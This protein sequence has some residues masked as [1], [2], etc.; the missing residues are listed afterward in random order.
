M[1]YRH[2]LTILSIVFSFTQFAPAADTLESK[3]EA[4]LKAEPYANAHWGLLVVDSK[5]GKVVFEKNADQMF[6]PASVT[7]LFSTSAAFVDLGANHK[8]ETPVVRRGPVDNEGTL[9]GDLILVASGDLSLGGRTGPAGTLLFEDNDHIY[10]G[11]SNTGTLV[12]CD[13]LAGL[14]ELAK[15]ILASGIKRI[16][17][18]VL[19]DDRMFEPSV[20]TG[21]G[22]TH[23]SP[24][25]INDSIVD[26]L[27]T[28]GA[29][30]GDTAT[31]RTIPQ[32]AF[33]NVE[34]QVD[35]VPEGQRATA[36]VRSVGSRAF[37]VRGRVPVGHKP[38]LRIF[39]IDDPA[40]YARSLFIETLRRRGIKVSAPAVGSNPADR[41]PSRTEVAGMPRVASYTSPAF[42]EYAKVILKVSHN[43][44]ASTLPLLIAANHGESNLSQG[45]R[46]Q[47][48][49]LEK[50][51][52]DVSSISF[53]GGAGG[54]RED[55]VTPRATVTLLRAMADRPD[56]SSFE[57]A[58]P[59]LGV[60]GTLA[61]SVGPDSPAKGHAKAKTGTYWND[62]AVNGKSVITSKALAGV[63]DT[64]EG[65]KLTFAFFMNNIPVDATGVAVSEATSA[66][67]KQ[68][69]KL[70][71]VFYAHK[72][73]ATP[74]K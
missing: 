40:A 53:G 10:A 22:P 58:L 18:D 23:V 57:A 49:I 28:P 14:E 3:V 2:M 39:T 1:K 5:T 52:V 61:K 15:G 13:P 9:R 51:G 31:V 11:G 45:L 8:F 69:G 27:I 38:I 33:V 21:S 12:P 20:S 60:D 7:K 50:L 4:V 70:C 19:I 48:R 46:R 72:A 17:G 47:G 54:A 41:L 42:S 44:H 73:E 56:Y 30:A 74:A 26:V 68:L 64:A 55:L 6:G 24:I 71:E 67:G 66:A 16:E 34:A 35:T 65:Q 25:M 37:Q 36:V 29:K 32:T 63:I 59:I 43:L 62:N